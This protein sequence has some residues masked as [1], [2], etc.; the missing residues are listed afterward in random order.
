MLFY[1]KLDLLPGSGR[2]ALDVLPP[3]RVTG[4][5][6]V[7]TLLAG[8]WEAFRST[9]RH[10][11]LPAFVLGFVNL[12]IITRQIRASMLDV[13]QEDYIRTARAN[14]LRRGAVILRHA[15]RNALIPSVTLLGLAFGD[16]LYGAVLTE[17]VF[18]WPGM[19]SYVVTSIQTLDFP[20]IMGFTVVASIG[21]VLVNLAVDMAY[22]LLDPQIREVG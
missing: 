10:L 5:Y 20:A 15:L 8:D 19:G 9:V 16:L 3:D 21:Y 7:D 6:L 12:G 22:M 2:I 18:A 1:A 17:T 13:L 14:G 11:I 4:F